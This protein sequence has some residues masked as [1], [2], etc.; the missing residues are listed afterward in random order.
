MNPEIAFLLERI[1]TENVEAIN[2]CLIA[3]FQNTD[4][5]AALSNLL[6]NLWN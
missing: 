4:L 2:F 3:S 6:L 1:T 5:N